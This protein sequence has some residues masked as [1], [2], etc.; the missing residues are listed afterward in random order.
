MG[1]YKIVL[2]GG[3]ELILVDDPFW[4]WETRGN[5][6]DR[7]M[8]DANRVLRRYRYSPAHGQPGALLIELT[9]RS[10]G[11]RADVPEPP[12]TRPGAVY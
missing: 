4:G 10:I 12:P 3:A 2:S 1:D 6:S 9:V 8:E 11:G 5:V 7:T